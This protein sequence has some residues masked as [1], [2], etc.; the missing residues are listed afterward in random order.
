MRLEMTDIEEIK[1]LR[2][3]YVGPFEVEGDK[4]GIVRV[5]DIKK[6]EGFIKELVE[7]VERLR[8]EGEGARSPKGDDPINK[9]K[10]EGQNDKT[11]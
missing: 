1:A 9:K 4:R 8:K 7:E 3:P 5:A 6:A 11:G 10:A 2:I